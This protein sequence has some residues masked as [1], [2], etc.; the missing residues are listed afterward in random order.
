MQHTTRRGNGAHDIHSRVVCELPSLSENSR[1]SCARSYLRR[2]MILCR[3]VFEKRASLV[4]A[5]CVSSFSQDY[6]AE[7]SGRWKMR[8]SDETS[9]RRVRFILLLIRSS[10]VS[11][12]RDKKE[13][14][15]ACVSP[16]TPRPS[17]ERIYIGFRTQNRSKLL[18]FV[19]QKTNGGKRSSTSMVEKDPSTFYTCMYM[20]PYEAN[21]KH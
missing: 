4:S 21:I 19:P 12:S 20:S 17:S 8:V 5:T 16:V 6:V 10:C 14:F 1:L 3:I 13:D 9:T 18:R 7:I 15:S 11:V 2:R